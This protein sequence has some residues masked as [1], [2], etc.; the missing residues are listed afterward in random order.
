MDSFDEQRQAELPLTAGDRLRGAREAVGL[1]RSDIASQT[2]I[3]ERHLLAIEENR[4][5]DLAARTYAVGFARAYARALGL[6]EAE[7]AAEVRAQLDADHSGRPEHVQ[8]FEPGDP[9]RV[10]PVR[11]AWLA[12]AGAVLVIGL[13]LAFW[14]SYLSPEG[15]L[16]D[17]LPLET[18]KPA[19]RPAPPAVRTPAPVQGPVVLT[20]IADG[21]WFAVTDGGG[22]RLVDRTLAKGESWTVPAGV[23]APQLRTGRPDALQISV[24]GRA[25]AL[26]GDKPATI[27]GV[28][29]VAADLLTRP[30]GAAPA[31]VATGSAAP[32]SGAGADAPTPRAQSTG[33]SASRQ[34]ALPGR[35]SSPESPSRP[36]GEPTR[37]PAATA[38]APAAVP[39]VAVP[40]APAVAAPAGTVSTVSN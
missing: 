22:A 8:S 21:V 5:G 7:I 19:A 31:V 20:A 39:P 30:N 18:P 11:L 23:Q 15:R 35:R 40:T 34:P 37:S 6:D 24:G 4:F 26:L 9:A 1:S 10:P 33:P 17:L 13:L 3:A 36:A 29:L 38:T 25:L 2:K 27:S 16:P 12:A 28:S 32:V 14:G